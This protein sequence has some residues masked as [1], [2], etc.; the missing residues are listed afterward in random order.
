VS[1]VKVLLARHA[2][3]EANAELR[4]VGSGDTPLTEE[5]KRQSAEL[6]ARIA[7][8]APDAV[9]SSP[10]RRCLVVAAPVA[11]ALHLEARVLEELGEM[12]FGLAEGL[13]YE[14]LTR[15]G[16]SMDL[17]GGPGNAAPFEGGEDWDAFRARVA[18][19]AAVIERFGERVAVVTHGGVIRALVTHWL[20]LPDDAAWRFAIA[21]AG[22]VEIAIEDGHGIL[23]TLGG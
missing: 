21:P 10:S 17:L 16:I 8:W 11:E 2:E 18:E 12:D 9:L 23:T 15:A 13:T 7:D 14:E 22:V 19:G 3:T 4:Y 1:S 20:A 6:I 5:G